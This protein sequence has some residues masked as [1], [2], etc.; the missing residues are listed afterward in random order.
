MYI[1]DTNDAVPTDRPSTNRAAISSFA[2]CE[3]AHAMA[4]SVYTTPDTILV[5]RRPI[6][7]D[8]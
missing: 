8:R 6:L 7:R 1:G 5:R 2:D 3:R 4:A